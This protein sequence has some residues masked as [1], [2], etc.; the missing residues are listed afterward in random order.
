MPRLFVGTFLSDDGIERL[1]KL[2]ADNRT[3][4]ETW[5][6]KI[7]WTKGDKLH[8]TW[9]FLGDVDSEAIPDVI[10]AL[11][12]AISSFTLKQK[13]LTLLYDRIELW[14]NEKQAR[15]AV[16]TPS[17]T[18]ADVF[19]LDDAVK[20]AVGKFIS[21][22]Q[23]QHEFKNFR[24]HLTL[25]RFADGQRR[26]SPI[27]KTTDIEIADSLMPLEHKINDLHLI[28]S[29]AQPDAHQYKSLERFQLNLDG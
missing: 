20:R 13:P 11:K 18:P 23:K 24:P 6:A 14:P 15:L 10:S 5:N 22:S 4:G 2:S 21:P 16:L 29:T 9:V 7:R 26:R 19:T 17:S 27:P 28:E 8:I 12:L 1:A 25:L 3:L